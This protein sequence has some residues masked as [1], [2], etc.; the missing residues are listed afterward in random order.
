MFDLYEEMTPGRKQK[1][2]TQITAKVSWGDTKSSIIQYGR[3][4]GLTTEEVKFFVDGAFKERA[5]TVRKAGLSYLTVAAVLLVIAILL[6]VIGA[7]ID[8]GMVRKIIS[9]P[10]IYLLCIG[11]FK[12]YKG[13][14]LVLVGDKN[15]CLTTLDGSRSLPG[16]MRL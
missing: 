7:F 13:S 8:L 16:I 10:M 12:L 15:C 9:L 3:T 5:S 1:I 11:L 4:E 14:M 2:V 6:L